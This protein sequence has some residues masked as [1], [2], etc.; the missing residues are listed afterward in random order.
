MNFG[1]LGLQLL[2]RFKFTVLPSCSLP[3]LPLGEKNGLLF[4]LI[5]LDVCGV[6]VGVGDT[7]D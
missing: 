4:F 1:P 6:G 5:Y 2:L 3:P 7:T